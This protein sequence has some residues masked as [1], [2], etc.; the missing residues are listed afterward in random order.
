MAPDLVSILIVWFAAG[1]MMSES[2]NVFTVR[3]VGLGH[4]AVDHMGERSDPS[5]QQGDSSSWH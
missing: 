5:S 3:R 1:A 2:Q 4:N